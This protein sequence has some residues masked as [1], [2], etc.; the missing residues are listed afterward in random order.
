MSSGYQLLQVSDQ[1]PCDLPLNPGWFIR[2]LIMADILLICLYNWV[3]FHPT[4]PTGGEL[5]TGP[6]NL[7]RSIYLFFLGGTSRVLRFHTTTPYIHSFHRISKPRNHHTQKRLPKLTANMSL[8]NRP[9]PK[10]KRL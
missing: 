2:I 10:S 4:Q 1:N 9:N 8:L 5:I 7:Q 6:S 3:R